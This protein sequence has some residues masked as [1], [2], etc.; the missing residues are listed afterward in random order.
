MGRLG[1][2]T[3]I[4]SLTGAHEYNTDFDKLISDASHGRLKIDQITDFDRPAYYGTSACRAQ[5]SSQYDG[6][7]LYAK[8]SERDN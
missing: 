2:K 8:D 5:S 4:S 7:R 1:N 6:R 3:K